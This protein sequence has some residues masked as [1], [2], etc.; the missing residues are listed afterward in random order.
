MHIQIFNP[1]Q[2]QILP[3]VKQ[4]KKE[5]Y[6]V[7]GTAIALHIGHRRSI[8]FDLFKFSP[9]KPQSIIQNISSFNFKYAVTRRVAEQLNVNINNVKFTFYQYPFKINATEKLD[10][11]LRLPS[12]LDLA[13][14]KA[15]ALGRRSK[16][17]DYVD[18]YFILK[19]HFSIQQISDRTAELFG[20]L[21]SEKLFRAQ[22]SYFDDID[23]SEPVEFLVPVLSNEEIRSFLTDKATDIFGDQPI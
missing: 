8:D 10:D 12:L 21:F 18:L 20:Q 23:Y 22:L 5:F 17:K 19:D 15:Y 4:F 2:F 6:L 3:L 14:M 1:D 13:A 7:G 16:W 9:I 11:I